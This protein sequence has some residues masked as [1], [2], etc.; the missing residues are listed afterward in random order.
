[1][2]G[3]QPVQVQSSADAVLFDQGHPGAKL[4]RKTGCGQPAGAGPDDDDVKV[5][6][7]GF[8]SGAK[9]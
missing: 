3:T 9:A 6:G 5:F 7:H 2:L 8:R 1:L 4:R